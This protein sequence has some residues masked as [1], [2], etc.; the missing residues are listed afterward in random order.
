MAILCFFHDEYKSHYLS[1]KKNF[2]SWKV[3]QLLVNK[4][5]KSAYFRDGWRK[6]GG[7]ACTRE[8]EGGSWGSGECW[9]WQCKVGEGEGVGQER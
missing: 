6:G 8:L 7:G 1:K 3:P 5:P 2:N 9:W 4:F